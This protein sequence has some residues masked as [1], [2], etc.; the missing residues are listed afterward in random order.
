MARITIGV[1]ISGSAYSGGRAADAVNSV[2]TATV[3][4]NVATLV[5]DGASPTQAHVTTL[6]TNWTALKAG[7]GAIPANTDVV[8][9]INTANITSIASLRHALDQVVLIAMGGSELT[10]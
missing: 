8:V 7:T 3:D 10:Q 4:A 1:T 6:D 5:A 9:S 2:S